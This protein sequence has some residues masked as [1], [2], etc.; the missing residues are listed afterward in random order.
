MVFSKTLSI[1]KYLMGGGRG[2]QAVTF[3]LQVELD[4][5]DETS[6]QEIRVQLDALLLSVGARDVTFEPFEEGSTIVT[7]ISKKSFSVDTLKEKITKLGEIQTIKYTVKDSDP[8]DTKTTLFSKVDDEELIYSNDLILVD[9]DNMT[10][11]AT[12]GEDGV[13]TR[14]IVD[15]ALPGRNIQC[16]ICGR[17]ARTIAGG[18][19]MDNI[20]FGLIPTLTTVN[21]G[22][23]NKIG[24][25]AFGVCESLTDIDFKQVQTIGDYAFAICISL[26][27]IEFKQVNEIG[28]GAFQS[29]ESLTTI[30]FKLVHTIGD[31]AFEFCE[32]LTDID[33]KHVNKIGKIAFVF[34]ES[35][36]D[37]DLKHVKEIGK[38]AFQG[39]TELRE[40]RLNVA[41][42]W[43]I[44]A[45]CFRECPVVKGSVDNPFLVAKDINNIEFK[46]DNEVFSSRSVL[47]PPG[48][49]E[50]ID[51]GGFAPYKRVKANK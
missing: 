18:D 13:I 20:V 16:V 22:Q 33:F 45:F 32:L 11:Y 9:T 48:G 36:T 37:I 43:T 15:G 1:T 42:A 4:Q 28:G 46:S 7:A 41:Q 31:D 50:L 19:A 26:T 35:L 10:Y 6:Q 40:V 25:G 5:L 44:P 49:L 27:T 12:V 38:Y 21:L 30:D 47:T 24:G 3:T 23:V 14:A 39:C 17:N 8:K 51:D 2:P 29:C 34:C